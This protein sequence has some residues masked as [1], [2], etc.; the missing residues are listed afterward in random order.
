M[1]PLTMMETIRM[2]IRTP[3]MTALPL[4]LAL[5]AGITLLASL[6]ASA[7]ELPSPMQALKQQGFTFHGQFEAPGGLEGYA[8][9]ASGQ[10]VA[11][12]LTADGQHAVVG[13]L[14]DAQGDNVSADA[15]Q[16]LVN[17]PKNAKLWEQMAD[18]HWVREGDA[19]A[20]RIVYTFSDPNCPYCRKFWEDARPWVESGRVQI[21]HLM[22]GVLKPDSAPKAAALLSADAPAEAI[23]EHYRTGTMPDIAGST[24]SQR[25]VSAN[26]ELMQSAELYATPVIFYRDDEG[27]HRVMGAPSPDK[28]RD[29]MGSEAP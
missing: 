19:D 22:V 6:P 9:S 1:I 14:I 29:I 7:D 5:G 13:T 12:Y 4:A 23:A 25:H 16:R 20:E 3:R 28:L 15:L 17:G 2:P 11:A 10:T 26:T 21:R 24:Q 8:A 18:Q 27:V